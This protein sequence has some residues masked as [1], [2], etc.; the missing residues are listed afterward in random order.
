ML[1]FAVEALSL[2]SAGAGASVPGLAL[3]LP[4]VDG[5]ELLGL[6]LISH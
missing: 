3:D 1:G 6:L 2:G 4:L 5:L